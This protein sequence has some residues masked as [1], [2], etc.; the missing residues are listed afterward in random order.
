MSVY[1]CVSETKRSKRFLCGN[2]KV[3]HILSSENLENQEPKPPMICLYF[4]QE[5]NLI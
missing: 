3:H 1:V 4:P 5:E 2:Q